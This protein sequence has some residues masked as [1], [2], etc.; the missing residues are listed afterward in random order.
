MCGRAGRAGH[1]AA[2][3]SYMLCE[4]KESVAVETMLRAKMLPSTSQLMDPPKMK[5]LLLEGMGNGAVRTLEHIDLFLQATLL[6]HSVEWV[7]STQAISRC[8][9]CQN[10]SSSGVHLT[11]IF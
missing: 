8:L 5:K 10:R 6:Y 4:A 9:W 7:V 11:Y 2:G 1:A 3:D